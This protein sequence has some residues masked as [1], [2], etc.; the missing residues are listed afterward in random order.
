[1]R[2][3]SS[4]LLA[5]LLAGSLTAQSPQAPVEIRTPDGS[6]FLLLPT[7]GTDLVHWSIASP[8]GPAEDPVGFEGLALATL[9]ASMAGTWRTGS[10]EPAAEQ[11]ALAALDR[12]MSSGGT[13]SAQ[14]V[15]MAAAAQLSDARAFL[16][17]LA[18]APAIDVVQGERNGCGLLTLTTSGA[19]LERVAA[20]LV[21][22]REQNALRT[23][24]FAWQGRVAALAS[25]GAG[26][27]LTPLRAEAWA[28]AFP[29][30]PLGRVGD[31]VVA[32]IDREKATEV[33][34]NTQ[35]PDRTVHV[36]TGS[37][38]PKAVQAVLNRT[39]AISALTTEPWTPIAMPAPLA[40]E[41]RS[42]MPGMSLPT[43]VIGWRLR[44]DEDAEALAQLALWLASGP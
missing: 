2:K 44:G 20:M 30:H 24:Q 32:V 10:K 28:L 39:F 3:P 12:V 31:R 15:A 29:G 22:R 42:A 1:M 26:D 37:F 36:L 14:A 25:R 38:D 7:G 11:R 27:P 33:W 4:W 40:A 23:L 21:E 35:R 43:C 13:P 19:G 17:V 41:R 34:L 5:S 16:R 8:A 9:E 18:S 6:R